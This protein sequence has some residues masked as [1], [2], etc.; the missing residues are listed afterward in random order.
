MVPSRTV[1]SA[2]THA[3]G[4]VA[5]TLATTHVK[6]GPSSAVATTTTTTTTSTT[7]CRTPQTPGCTLALRRTQP[8][9]ETDLLERTSSRNDNVSTNIWHLLCS[10]FGTRCLVH[11]LY[12]WTAET[13]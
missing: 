3:A 13:L 4:G 5:T 2:T 7:T 10:S 9:N 12:L 8:T 11:V 6:E 1:A